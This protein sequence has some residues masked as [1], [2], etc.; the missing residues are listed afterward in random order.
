MHILCES[1]KKLKRSICLEL[2]ENGLKDEKLIF[3]IYSCGALLSFCL[4]SL[5]NC[6]FNLLCFDLLVEFKIGGGGGDIEKK[7]KKYD[8]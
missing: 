7:H 1:I 4:F 6:L 8:N 3:V 5:K 2:R